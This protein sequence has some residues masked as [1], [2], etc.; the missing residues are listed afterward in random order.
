ML[1]R[2]L[3]TFRDCRPDPWNHW[4]KQLRGWNLWQD[5]VY[6][7]NCIIMLEHVFGAYP[8]CRINFCQKK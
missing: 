1:N 4:S 6:S 3:S 8:Y 2:I 7:G 5:D